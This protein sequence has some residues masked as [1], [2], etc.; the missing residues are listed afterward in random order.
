MGNFRRG[1]SAEF[2]GMQ[3]FGV[4]R[5]RNRK[6]IVATVIDATDTRF[7][8]LCTCLSILAL[9]RAALGKKSA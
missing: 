9:S 1:F 4:C 6:M 5:T 3:V 8:N 7:S 2:D